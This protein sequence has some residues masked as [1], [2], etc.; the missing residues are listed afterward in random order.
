MTTVTDAPTLNRDY[1]FDNAWQHAGERL[2]LLQAA[3]DPGT[4]HHLEHLNVRLGWNCLEVAAG[5][6]SI[7]EWLCRRVGPSGRVVATDIDT[8]FL[9]ANHAS[10]TRVLPYRQN[11]CTSPRPLTCER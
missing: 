5:A 11:L 1:V 9:E 8:R 7:A 2:T 4:I 3:F 6:G 10:N